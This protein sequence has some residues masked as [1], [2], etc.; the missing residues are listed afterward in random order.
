LLTIL[1]IAVVMVSATRKVSTVPAV[2][3]PSTC[4]ICEAVV[5]MGHVYAEFQNLNA[6]ALD[7]ELGKVCSLLPMNY[8]SQCTVMV[9]AFGLAEC[10]CI[11]TPT[12]AFNATLCCTDV[13]LCSSND[14]AAETKAAAAV[15]VLAVSAMPIVSAM[16]T[17]C[18]VCES[19]ATTANIIAQYESWNATMLQAKLGL[20]CGF[21]PM[22]YQMQC[23]TLVQTFGAIECQCITDPKFNAQ[24]CC[25]D[26]GVCPMPPL[27][28]PATVVVTTTTTTTTTVAAPRVDYCSPC[29]ALATAA[30]FVAELSGVNGT[31]LDADLQAV[32]TYVP[33]EYQSECDDVIA[34]AGLEVADCVTNSTTFDAQTC[35][36]EA[37]LCA[38][39]S[40]LPKGLRHMRL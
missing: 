18:D 38:K 36:F 4:Q 8:Q 21:V 34:I 14:V 30:H 40:K 31:V 27:T 26:V 7:S 39:A 28:K 13:A 15:T 19:A 35:C 17:E 11:T 33:V 3:A 24:L 10:Q 1:V 37:G 6:T 2:K 29:K 20:V 32:C 5:M 22:Q 25:S 23:Q 12:A 16:P 9:A